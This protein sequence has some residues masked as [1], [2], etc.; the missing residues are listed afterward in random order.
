MNY[1]EAQ[2]GGNKYR[3]DFRQDI[4]NF[5]SELRQQKYN[6]SVKKA[7]RFLNNHDEERM[8]LVKTLGWPLTE[9][10]F[11]KI[12]MT[13]EKVVQENG[14]TVFRV[15]FNIFSKIRYY[16]LA[17]R[18]LPILCKPLKWYR[19]EISF[20]RLKICQ[21]TKT[22]RRYGQRKKKEKKNYE[23]FCHCLMWRT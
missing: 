19:I 7:K 13:R 14:V 9:Y 2:N 10:N 3:I 18:L 6:E 23:N 5:V 21:G 12:Q 17:L 11:D 1:K 15:V 4:N 22:A 20:W 16:G 8:A